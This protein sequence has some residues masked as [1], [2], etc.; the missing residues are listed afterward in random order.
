[1]R[2]VLSGFDLG[3]SQ[4]FECPL[5]DIKA[6]DK[7]GRNEAD[8]SKHD[9]RRWFILHTSETKQAFIPEESKGLRERPRSPGTFSI[10]A[11]E[12][13]T[14]AVRREI[15]LNGPHIWHQRELI[16]VFFFN[17]TIKSAIKAKSLRAHDIKF[18]P[19][20]LV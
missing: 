10:H 3:S 11:T 7:R 6:S 2:D 13:P 9:P 14:V 5:F 16:G 8:R 17:D 1:M 4:F 15:A 20:L 19:C 18:N 12:K